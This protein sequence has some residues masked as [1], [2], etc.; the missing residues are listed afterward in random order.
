[1]LPQALSTGICSLNPEEDRLCMTV[2]LEID[3]LGE[4]LQTEF[5]PIPNPQPCPADLHPGQGDAYARQPAGHRPLS[6]SLSGPENHG[7][8]LSRAPRKKDG[9]GFHRLRPS[10]TRSCFGCP[11]QIEEIVLAERH[12]G[13]QII[14][15]SIFVGAFRFLGVTILGLV[16][17]FPR[18]SWEVTKRVAPPLAR[19]YQRYP[20]L[21]DNRITH[22]MTV[23]C[24]RDNQPHLSACQQQGMLYLYKDFC[25]DGRCWCCPSSSGNGTLY[26]RLFYK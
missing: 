13:H 20:P 17:L 9:A 12:I 1:M 18:G 4:V 16:L 11:G 23:Q 26:D 6:Y 2:V 8:P 3:G 5:F 21:A 25:T 10:R 14:G 7:R 24:F 15:D 22:M 19:F